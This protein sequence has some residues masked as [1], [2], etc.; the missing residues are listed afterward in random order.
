MENKNLLIFGGIGLVALILM[1][2][3]K[4]TTESEETQEESLPGGFGGGGYGG[5]IPPTP[6]PQVQPSTIVAKPPQTAPNP[7]FKP[8]GDSGTIVSCGS[9]Y[10]YNPATRKC[11]VMKPVQQSTSS[12]RSAYESSRTAGG[13]LTSAPT[14]GTTTTRPTTG[15]T[16]PPVS[17]STSS[18]PVGGGG[19]NPTCPKG[20]MYNSVTRKC[21]K[22]DDGEVGGGGMLFSGKQP[23]TIDNLLC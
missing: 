3:K 12:G 8:K 13:G 18:R 4:P 2:K 14:G 16:A 19:T 7:V 1:S 15:S 22:M 20:Y 10:I 21:V 23:L 9:G 6:M 17:G 11:E 5:Y